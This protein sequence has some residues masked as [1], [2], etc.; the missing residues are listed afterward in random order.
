MKK[1]LLTT[2][3]IGA[4]MSILGFSNFFGRNN[5]DNNESDGYA[6]L[7]KEIDKAENKDLPKTVVELC[8]K[9][10]QKAINEEN[11]GQ[12]LKAYFYRA[13]Y[14]IAL[15]PDSLYTR[16]K[17]LEKM[18]AECKE[19]VQKMALHSTIASIYS[20][21]A[22][23]N[24][25]QLNRRTNVAGGEKSSNVDEWGSQKFISTILENIESSLADYSAL[26][27]YSNEKYK[28]FV[29]QNYDGSYYNHDMLHIISNA[30][31]RSIHNIGHIAVDKKQL[32]NK[33]EEN[34]ESEASVEAYLK[35]LQLNDSY[36]PAS[37][38]LEYCNM[39]L[40]KFPKA[41]RTSAIK[42]VKERIL[43]PVVSISLPTFAYP[44]KKESLTL[45]HVN[46]DN[47]EITLYK[48]ND[49]TIEELKKRRL[50]EG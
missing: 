15:T 3:I 28:P 41:E 1:I 42:S 32:Q 12:F 26:A 22:R 46:S 13:D 10:I 33:I 18:A 40:E 5:G 23:N 50:E 48:L 29:I 31:I 30:A 45:Q 6:K 2:I 20:E 17:D 35:L 37:K 25:W 47:V 44:N 7:W 39:L 34:K 9:I 16:I 24:S 8:D 19:P 49:A 4:T 36:I 38:K 43:K 14:V 11:K 21:Y 27:N